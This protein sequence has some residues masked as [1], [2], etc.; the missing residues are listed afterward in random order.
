MAKSGGT[1]TYN[2]FVQ[3]LITEAS[4]LTF[5]ENASLDEENFILFR[6]GSRKRRLGM[7]YENLYNAIE[8]GIWSGTFKNYAVSTYKWQ[9]VGND[10]S[11]VIGVIQLGPKLFFVDLG[12]DTLSANALNDGDELLVGNAGQ[13]IYQFTSIDGRLIV[14]TNEKDPLYIEYKADEDTF[15]AGTIDIEIRDLIGL[16]DD[17]SV[18]ENPASLSQVHQ[19]NLLNQGW[20]NSKINSYKADSSSY[21][22]NTQVWFS[23]KD[24]SDN[25]SP[26]SLD[27][28]EFGTSPA[29]KGRFII[30]AFRR[31]TSRSVRAAIRN[32]STVTVTGSYTKDS[33]GTVTGSLIVDLGVP[34]A[35]E[36]TPY[37]DDTK[38][39]ISEYII[40]DNGTSLEVRFRE[41]TANPLIPLSGVSRQFK[42]TYKV[43]G[44]SA[45]TIPVDTELGH[46]GSVTAHAGRIFYSGITSKVTGGDS[47]SPSYTGWVFFSRTV[48]SKEHL[49]QCYQEA[50]PTSEEVS[51][52]VESD[53]GTINITG[54]AKIIKLVSIG[55]ILLVMASNGIWE[56]NG[57]DK[58]FLA[59]DYS[60]NKVSDIG[61]ISSASIVAVENNVYYWSD[62]GIY[63]LTPDSITG[64]YSPQNITESTIQTLVNDISSVAKEFVTG[65]YDTANKQISWL[66]NDSGDFDGI[67]SRHKY[68]K[69]LVLSTVLG[70]FYKHSISD[71]APYIAGY[72]PTPNFLIVDDTQAVVVGEDQVQVLGE[73]VGITQEVRSRGFST[74]KYLTIIPSGPFT[75]TFSHYKDPNF[76]DW[77]TFDSIGKDYSSFLITGQELFGDSLRKKG[78]TYIL[79]YFSITED[80]YVEVS[81]LQYDLDNPS[82]CLIQSR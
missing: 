12:K 40:V 24:A 8:S 38:A 43:T 28:V 79:C 32:T 44:G 21:P 33:G 54:A 3:G 18:D 82:S 42:V 73:D 26:A 7:D 61:V 69:E 66:Y 71:G 68:T 46:I 51:D 9:N 74:V 48:L 63:V 45:L 41:P 27:K 50:D 15:I 37:I 5:P 67:N 59:T 30:D 17:L 81:P 14:G 64:R 22:S 65:I 62:G 16:Q 53:G 55:D 72:L 47:K 70:A 25:F 4:A 49:G 77:Y 19:Y 52:L 39:D 76:L 11:L 58:G 1:K 36:I 75:F 10:A 60:V 29:A 78:V 2:T 80:G 34:A 35:K 31:G 6:D 20:D 57:T 13:D 56:V 23:G